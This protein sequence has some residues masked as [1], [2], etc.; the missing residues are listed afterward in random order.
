MHFLTKKEKNKHFVQTT[1]H[2]IKKMIRSNNKAAFSKKLRS[3]N[4]AI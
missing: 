3:N 4:K 1:K 2:F